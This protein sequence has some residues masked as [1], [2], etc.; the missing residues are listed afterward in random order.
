MKKSIIGI[1]TSMMFEEKDK[2]FLGYKYSYVADNYVRA[3]SESGGVPILLPII[4]DDFQIEEQ[5]KILD[6]LVL[7]G[8]FDIDPKFYNEEPL[9]KLGDLYPERDEFE[10]KLIKYALKYKVPMLGICRGFQLLNVAFGGNLYQDISYRPNSFIKH[11]Q[12]AKP[13][14]CTHSIEIEKKSLFFEIAN[15]QEN[16]RV[17]SYHHLALKDVAKDFKVVATAKDGIVEAIEYANDEQYILGV[18]FHPEMMFQTNNFAKN[19]FK[20]FIENCKK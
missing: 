1:S 11:C 8:G 10:L 16:E 5:V 4:E 13:E 12:D 6:G 7:S 18:Q 15:Q 2:F 3:V 20:N 19:I 14:D 9:E 17:N